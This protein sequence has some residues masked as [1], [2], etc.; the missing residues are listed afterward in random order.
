MMIRVLAMW[1][2]LSTPFIPTPAA[3]Q[4][5]VGDPSFP[6][7]NEI[8]WEMSASQIQGLCKD[9]WKETSSTDS[10][11]VYKSSFFGSA[12]MVKIQFDMKSKKARMIDIGFEEATIAM[13]DTLVNHLT[14][15]MGKPPVI[16]TKE[17]S[18]IIFTIKLE[19]AF[20]KSGNETIAVMTGMRG[21]SVVAV[22]LIL[23][24]TS[25]TQK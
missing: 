3:S 11:V 18:A 19:M 10:T 17:K 20:W 14:Q 7:L 4:G 1:V 5:L 22:S 25:V 23:T 8:R 9:K 24:P 13:R 12:S 15:I 2:L 16:T 6:V 21:S